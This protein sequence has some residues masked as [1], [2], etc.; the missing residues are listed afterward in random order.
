MEQPPQP[1]SEVVA[2]SEMFAMMYCQQSIPPSNLE[3]EGFSGLQPV[4]GWSG[5]DWN[6]CGRQYGFYPLSGN[7]GT[8]G[9]FQAANPLQHGKSFN[10]LCCDGHVTMVPILDLIDPQKTARRW[11]VDNQPHV[12]F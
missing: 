5:M 11:N 6:W 12:E 4:L 7:Y 2:P 1:G 8:G 9:T 3:T 10:V